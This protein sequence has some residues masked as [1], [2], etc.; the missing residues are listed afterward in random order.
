M[1][2]ESPAGELNVPLPG[3]EIEDQVYEPTTPVV[4]PRNMEISMHSSFA[5]IERLQK[6]D[7]G[8]DLDTKEKNPLLSVTLSPKDPCILVTAGH[9]GSVRVWKSEIVDGIVDPTLRSSLPVTKVT[10]VTTLSG[11]SGQVTTVRFSPTG[12]YLVSCSTDST[13][14]IYSER[15]WKLLHCLRAHTLDVI[16]V[17]W[18]SDS[19]LVSTGT[20]RN[21]IVWDATTGGRLQTLYSDK[22]SCPKGVVIDPKGDYLCILF[23]DGLIDVY[24]RNSDGRF[25]LAR[26]VNL[27]KDDPKN[28]AKAFKTTLYARRGT[29]SP[30][31]DHLLLPLGS[32][33]RHGP[34]G[35][36]YDRSNLLEPMPGE[37]L[38]AEK[39]LAGHPSRVVVV[40]IRPGLLKLTGDHSYYLTAMVSVDGVLSIWS[41]CIDRPVSIV[42]N[43]S[44]PLRVCTDAC[45]SGDRLFLSCSDGSVTCVELFNI[46]TP[47][48]AKSTIQRSLAPEASV[49]T[50]IFGSATSDVKSAQVELRVGG[51]RK[52]QPVVTVDIPHSI[53]PIDNGG[54]RFVPLK[55]LRSDFNGT[56][57]HVQNGDVCSTVSRADGWR[58]ELEGLVTCVAHNDKIVIFGVQSADG[59][60]RVSILNQ[61]G[62]EAHGKIYMNEIITS[63]H[64]S[65]ADLVCLVGFDKTLYVWRI[66]A[67]DLEAVIP[68]IRIPLG[69]DSILKVEVP[70]GVPQIHFTNGNRIRYHNRLMKW[71]DAN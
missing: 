71:F 61:D 4:T 69:N 39:V 45:W 37:C 26:H 44:G 57:V 8:M 32:R 40:A 55:E 52:I 62:V 66:S 56:T 1:E 16:D 22:G 12:D 11:H 38:V 49:S 34:C 65:D 54:T 43:I 2:V 51:K 53:H 10:Q 68:D 13:L 46:G 33:G 70:D 6:V 19:I 18:Y 28:Y 30:S 15:K 9:E 41:S 48:E 42:A 47:V 67:N 24:R 17:A 14:R 23:D 64:P 7:H 63:I 58:F 31:G 27:A 36:L 3:D 5:R 21:S 59:I 29:W 60:P 20:D 25:R 50:Q 35:V